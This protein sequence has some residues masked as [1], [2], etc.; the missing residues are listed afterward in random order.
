MSLGPSTSSSMSA[1]TPTSES[2][3]REGSSHS[4]PSRSANDTSTAD[5]LSVL[6]EE[7]MATERCKNTCHWLAQTDAAYPTAKSLGGEGLHGGFHGITTLQRAPHV[8]D[9]RL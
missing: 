6:C 8:V 7:S 2:P 3:G 4:N 5:T 1:S 9:G